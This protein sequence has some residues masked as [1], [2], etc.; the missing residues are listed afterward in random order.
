MKRAVFLSATLV[1]I[2]SSC[3]S[4]NAGTDWTVYLHRAGPIRIG[5]SLAEVRRVLGDPGAYLNGDNPDVPLEACAYL[6]SR[7]I[8]ERLGFIFTNGR[9]V[10]VD[11][12]DVNIRTASGG[13]LG[14]SEEK[15]KMLYPGRISVEA[16]HYLPETGHYLIYSAQTPAEREY[17]MVF[18]T[19]DGKVISFRTG[20]QSAIALVEG[21]S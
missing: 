18:E 17:G 4:I 10:R 16:H 20:T 5:M 8:P 13:G 21:C 7:A 6:E 9:V 3:P 2:G 11:V 14:D 15:I 19:E 1:V 12:D